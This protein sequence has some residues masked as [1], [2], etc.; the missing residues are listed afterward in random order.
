MAQPQVEAF[1]DRVEENTT[2]LL[3]V[4]LLERLTTG[5]VEALG[6]G[7]G[8]GPRVSRQLQ[9]R[10]EPLELIRDAIV[11]TAVDIW[12]VLVRVDVLSNLGCHEQRLNQ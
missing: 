2:K 7:F 1:V 4:L 6:E 11:F 10:K 12:V 3:H 5:P 9:I 8:R